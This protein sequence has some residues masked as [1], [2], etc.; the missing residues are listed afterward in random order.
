MK[1][2]RITSTA[3]IS[4]TDVIM[5]L[6]IFIL[7]TSTFITNSG[8]KIDL[9]ESSTKETDYSNSPIIS[10]TNN[11]EIFIDNT[12]V[13]KEELPVLLSE[14][15]LDKP[16]QTVIVYA[17]KQITIKDM[18]SVLDLAKKSGHNKFFLATKYKN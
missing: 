18:V 1:K 15:L 6:L 5:L 9:P 8:I 13:S 2:K 7:V 4:I 14:I 11:L 10:I 17:D 16:G 3:L 12:K